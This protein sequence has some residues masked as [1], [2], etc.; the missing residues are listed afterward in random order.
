MNSSAISNRNCILCEYCNYM[1]RKKITFSVSDSSSSSSA[2]SILC[3]NE[4]SFRL[5]KVFGKES[6]KAVSLGLLSSRLNVGLYRGDCGMAELRCPLPAESWEW[7]AKDSNSLLVSCGEG[8]KTG[9]PAGRLY[10]GPDLGLATGAAA[11]AGCT[12]GD[13]AVKKGVS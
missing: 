8:G 11:D 5:L 6:T 13:P 1:A 7:Y 4:P 12:C 3:I 9:G 10:A 2:V